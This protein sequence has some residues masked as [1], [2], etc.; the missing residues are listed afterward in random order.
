MKNNQDLLVNNLH[1]AEIRGFRHHLRNHRAVWRI[2]SGA[3]GQAICTFQGKIMHK[4]LVF[5]ERYVYIVVTKSHGE[6][7]TS[8]VLQLE[9]VQ[10]KGETFTC[11]PAQ[12]SYTKPHSEKA[13]KYYF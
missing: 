4:D 12:L 8:L 5:P 1:K 10:I 2:N 13:E 7:H 9:Y 6:E 11:S 3:K